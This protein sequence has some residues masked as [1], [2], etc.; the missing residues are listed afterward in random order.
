MKEN[1]KAHREVLRE[2]L[3]LAVTAR[4]ETNPAFSLRRLHQ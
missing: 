3:R 4:A 2:V 1:P